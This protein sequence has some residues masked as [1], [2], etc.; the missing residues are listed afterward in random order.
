ME[1][2]INIKRGQVLARS[3][4]FGPVWRVNHG[5]FRLE[6]L[7]LDGMTLVQLALPGDLLGVESL[8][9]V[10]YAYTVTAIT[11]SQA[12]QQSINHELPRFTA[13]AQG[14][15]Q[16][17]RRLHDMMQMRSGP[18]SE[19]LAHFLKLL[20]INEDGSSRELERRELPVLKEVAAILDAATETVCRELNAFLPARVYQRT[21]HK[22]FVNE[23]WTGSAHLALAA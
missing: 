3:G 10:P 5:V 9:S 7:G 1:K 19:R 20:A 12:T 15:L 14:Y 11:A 21:T 16:Q 6:R 22:R 23:A 13:V 8:C 18:V 17:Q 4:E 2:S